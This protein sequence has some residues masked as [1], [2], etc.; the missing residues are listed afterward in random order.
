MSYQS[1]VKI[2]ILPLM[3]YNVNRLEFQKYRPMENQTRKKII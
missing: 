2:F 1:L 3:I